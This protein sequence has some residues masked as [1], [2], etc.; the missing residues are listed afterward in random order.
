MVTSDESPKSTCR[1]SKTL[2]SISKMEKVK[3]SQS[4]KDKALKPQSQVSK[5]LNCEA[6]HPVVSLM[7]VAVSEV[8]YTLTGYSP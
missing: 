6:K 8:C 4:K 3:I 5:Q 1:W 7:K 2:A